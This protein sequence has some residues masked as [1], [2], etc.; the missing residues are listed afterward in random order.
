MSPRMLQVDE[1]QG[2]ENKEGMSRA[3]LKFQESKRQSNTKPKV[4][5]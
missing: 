1:G 4:T 3:K 2:R 5:G